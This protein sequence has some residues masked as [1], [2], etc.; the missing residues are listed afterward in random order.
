MGDL[1]LFRDWVHEG[2]EEMVSIFN[3][4]ARLIFAI[5]TWL[6]ELCIQIGSLFINRA[7]RV[8]ILSLAIAVMSGV[9]LYLTL[10]YITQI[11]M[12]EIN[13]LARAM[14]EY[15]SPAIL[16]AW[17]LGTVVISIGILLF[18]R[19]QRSAEIGAW[20]GC[21]VLGWLMVHWFGFIEINQSLGIELAQHQQDSS[22]IMI[23]TGQE[24]GS[25]I[26]TVID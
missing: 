1:F 14:M 22:W 20:I 18:I 3:Q 24:S 13:P 7:F 23:S 4:S 10:L 26:F 21:F 2:L 11:G 12:N 17:K 9:D 15:Q 16:A 6:K 25:G 5:H 8:V 19:K